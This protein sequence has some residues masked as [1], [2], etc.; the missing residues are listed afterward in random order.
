MRIKGGISQTFRTQEKRP[1]PRIGSKVPECAAFPNG[2]P[3]AMEVSIA[4]SPEGVS[5]D[6]DH[7]PGCDCKSGGPCK[8]F[9]ARKNAPKIRKKTKADLHRHH[10]D[11]AEEHFPFS[12]D[13]MDPALTSSHVRA[14]IAELRPVLPKPSAIGPLHDPSLGTAHG[15]GGHH[16]LTH[17]NMVFSPYG[18]AYEYTHGYD[19]GRNNDA[20]ISSNPHPYPNAS[21]RLH[22][23]NEEMSPDNVL[24][25]TVPT[26]TSPA[27]L[28]SAS[29]GCDDLCACPGCVLHRGEAAF[30]VSATEVLN[31]CTNTVDC[32]ERTESQMPNVAS[33]TFDNDSS[34]DDW[35]R[36]FIPADATEEMPGNDAGSIECLW[37]TFQVPSSIL[38]V[39][40]LDFTSCQDYDISC[41]CPPGLCKCGGTDDLTLTVLAQCTQFSGTE[42]LATDNDSIFP[43]PDVTVDANGYLMASQPTLSRSSSSSSLESALI[44]SRQRAGVVAGYPSNMQPLTLIIPPNSSPFTSSPPSTSPAHSDHNA[45]PSGY[46]WH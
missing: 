20:R 19:H 9:T 13:V 5:S 15:H 31:S 26:W 35:L 32:V 14:R 24:P 18:R 38:D 16:H 37:Q 2:L 21:R 41:M 36:L 42:N 28:P 8:C 3:E 4:L 23:M 46:A 10:G 1:R 34:V 22:P 33:S 25:P 30:A 40:Q 39:A 29:C 11:D 7:A 44:P 43:N 12:V 17:E 27:T 6:S 45:H